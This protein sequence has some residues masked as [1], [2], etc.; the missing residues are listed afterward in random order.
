MDK[1]LRVYGFWEIARA[2]ILGVCPN[3]WIL[4]P[5]RQVKFI[6]I[7]RTHHNLCANA[8]ASILQNH[9]KNNR[10]FI[11]PNANNL[12]SSPRE[13]SYRTTYCARKTG[14]IPQTLNLFPSLKRHENSFS[15]WMLFSFMNSHYFTFLE[16]LC[17]FHQRCPF[18]QIAI[19]DQGFSTD[20][21]YWLGSPLDKGGCGGQEALPAHW[22]EF[23][24]STLSG[25]TLTQTLLFS[26]TILLV[27]LSGIRFRLNA[28]VK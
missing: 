23:N 7:L 14:G 8:L 12:I 24:S 18:N 6:F 10:N 19:K 9:N 22:R 25:Y 5:A 27:Q 1:R 15:L 13:L 4:I 2:F 17:T 20:C 16:A 3:L 28:L 21:Q 26:S 11:I